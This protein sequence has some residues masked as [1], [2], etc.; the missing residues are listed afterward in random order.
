MPVIKGFKVFNPDWTC[1]DYD[2]KTGIGEGDLPSAI[3]TT[4][5][6]NSDVELCSKGFHF[7]E[8]IT[9]CFSYYPFNTKNK[10]AIVEGTGCSE[11]GE[12]CSKRSAKILRIVSEINW[13]DLLVI[14]NNGVDNT[15][16]SNTGDRN[17]GDCNIV[18]KEQ[19]HLIQNKQH[20]FEFSIS[21]VS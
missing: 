14:A 8:R 12:G 19:A 10:V 5:I 20:Q 4:H 16:H 21:I 18:N 7:C 3:G 6:H 11:S 9:D 2:F 1:R 17:T 15:G 13:A